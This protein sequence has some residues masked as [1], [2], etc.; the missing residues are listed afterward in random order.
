MI[1]APVGNQ[2]R[3]DPDREI[4]VRI[5]SMRIFTL[6]PK[7]TIQKMGA[8]LHYITSVPVLASGGFPI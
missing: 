5:R 2:N 4:G 7:G 8:R 3:G 6:T 1:F